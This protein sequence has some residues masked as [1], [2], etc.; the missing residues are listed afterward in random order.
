VDL[1][2]TKPTPGGVVKARTADELKEMARKLVGEEESRKAGW[3]AEIEKTFG[4]DKTWKKG[5][6]YYTH[7]LRISHDFSK[8]N[9]ACM[10][11]NTYV[12]SDREREALVRVDSNDGNRIWLNGEVIS[13]SPAKPTR[14]FH[15]STDEAEGKLKKGWN[16]LMI[17]V[18]NKFGEWLMTAQ[19][20]D[21]NKQP[22]PDLTYQLENPT[23]QK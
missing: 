23:E 22:L 16:Q 4:G 12:F 7:V 14:G 9:N 20:T 19:I 10:Y 18:E 21:R 3:E 13:S 5:Y 2:N 11:A 1:K 15:D 8:A 6:I 17:Q